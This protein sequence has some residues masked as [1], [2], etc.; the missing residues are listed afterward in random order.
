MDQLSPRV[1]DEEEHVQS[2]EPTCLHDQQVGGP[3]PFQLV[4][5]KRPP[6]LGPDGGVRS[7]TVS[8]DRSVA[9]YDPELEEL[10]SDS[11][12]TPKWVLSGNPADEF[13]DLGADART[14]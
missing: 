13:A 8:A 6:P 11:L 12:A 1:G 14:A 3:Y 10:T 7:P 4:G 9:D 5:E 2:P